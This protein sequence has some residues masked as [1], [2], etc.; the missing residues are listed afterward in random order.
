MSRTSIVVCQMIHQFV[1]DLFIIAV[2]WAIIVVT[3]F[4]DEQ[5]SALSD[6]SDLN[7]QWAVATARVVVRQN[8]AVDR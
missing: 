4:V 1:Q 3:M 6:N 5:R 2:I 8:Q 7:R